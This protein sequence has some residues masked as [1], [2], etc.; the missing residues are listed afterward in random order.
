MPIKGNAAA[1]LQGMT[2]A[3][4]AQ[5]RMITRSIRIT[6]DELDALATHFEA[7]EQTVTQ[8]IRF[9]IRQYMRE[10]GIS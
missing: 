1:R 9:I 10:N 3:T 2:P 8:G 6:Q 4:K 7:Q 5:G